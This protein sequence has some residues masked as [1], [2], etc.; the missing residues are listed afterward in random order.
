MLRINSNIPSL[1]VQRNLEATTRSIARALERLSSG[2]RI[3]SARDDVSGAA[4][5]VQL[6]ADI[7]A[8]K[9]NIRNI[10]DATSLLNVADSAIASQIEI[11]Q[12]MREIAVQSANGT[13]SLVDRESLDTELQLLYQ[14]FQRITET[15]EFNGQKLLDGSLQTLQIQVGPDQGQKIDLNFSSTRAAEVF[16]RTAGTGTFSLASTAVGSSSA[17]GVKFADFNGDGILDQVFHRDSSAIQIALGNGDGTF[18]SLSSIFESFAGY[19]PNS[20]ATTDVNNDGRTD[21][22]S[23]F[24]NSVYLGNGDGSFA[25]AI[26]LGAEIA[27]IGVVGDFNDDGNV[28]IV[29]ASAIDGQIQLHLGLGNGQFSDS[30]V[31][32]SGISP[33]DI[34]TNAQNG[35]SLVLAE[36]FD[37]DGHLDIAVTDGAGVLEVM[38]GDGQGG[39]EAPQI[40][41]AGKAIGA[42]DISGD[43]RADIITEGGYY[44][45]SASGYIANAVPSVPGA[46]QFFTTDF[47]S[48]GDMDIFGQTSAG[49][50][51]LINEGSAQSFSL[52]SNKAYLGSGLASVAVGDLNGDGIA[53]YTSYNSLIANYI[54]ETEQVS[55]ADDVSVRSQAEAQDLLEILDTALNDL[56]GKRSQLG[57]QQNRLEFSQSALLNSQENFSESLSRLEDADIAEETSVLIRQQILQQ[58]QIATLAQANFTMQAVLQL[59]R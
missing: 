20:I 35:G 6:R 55:A 56:V 39:F 13:L 51:I 5:A 3:N 9:Q 37:G 30:T 41:F 46:S 14:E 4:I 44:T 59:L 26:E 27:S 12:R 34:V 25:S 24:D 42:G 2:K 17:L 33:L 50:Q 18:G 7:N 22:V 8:S 49:V 47:D 29:R 23:F 48:D 54:A 58:A 38:E 53:D 28:D 40:L 15:T 10:N 52:L 19:G 32:P 43:G 21:V 31:L 1:I 16:T 11:V 57:A 45:G 36:D